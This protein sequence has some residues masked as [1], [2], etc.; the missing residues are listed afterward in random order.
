MTERDTETTGSPRAASDDIDGRLAAIAHDTGESLELLRSL[1]ALM[2]AKEAGHDGPRL[3]DLIAALV[4]QQRDMMAALRQ[5]QADV[6]AIAR[7]VLD[8]PDRGLNGRDTAP[9]PC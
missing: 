4:A 8:E 3:E 5:L 9:R 6:T 7:H 1:V 2:L